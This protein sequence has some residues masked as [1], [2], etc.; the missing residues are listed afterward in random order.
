MMAF[1]T[2]CLTAEHNLFMIS[3]S[4]SLSHKN[5]NQSNSCYPTYTAHNVIVYSLHFLENLCPVAHVYVLHLTG[6]DK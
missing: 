5:H 6:W 2:G 4:D 1:E 3:E